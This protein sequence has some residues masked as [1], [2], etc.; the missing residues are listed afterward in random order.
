ME[1]L[2]LIW[3]FCWTGDHSSQ[4]AQDVQE[5]APGKSGSLLGLPFR[6]AL[7]VL[8]LAVLIVMAPFVLV[9][10]MNQPIH[11]SQP[12]A[13]PVGPEPYSFTIKLK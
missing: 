6:L 10:L 9:V 13:K 4:P 2:F 3:L 12:K 11:L 8:L 7:V 1:L 5:K